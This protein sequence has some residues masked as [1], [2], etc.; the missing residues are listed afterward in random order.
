MEFTYT[1]KREW[2]S[3]A[4]RS[5]MMGRHGMVAASQPLAALAGYKILLNGGNAVDAAIAMVST[6]S[7]VEPYSVGLGG[8]AFALIYLAG[9]KEPIG[10]NGSGRAPYLARI[11]SFRER[12]LEEIPERGILSVT[13]P[14]ST[15]WMGRGIRALWDINAF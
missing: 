5:V 9:Q 1:Q 3:A 12:G 6:Q 15:P 10:M 8:D 4:Q 13:V 2:K 7:V 11:E 14:G